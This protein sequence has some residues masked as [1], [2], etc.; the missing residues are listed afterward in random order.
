MAACNPNIIDFIDSGECLKDSFYKLNSNFN[1]LEDIVCN[2]QQRLDKKTQ[3]RTFFYYGPNADTNAQSGMD[4][5]NLSR[6]SDLTITAF[7]NSPSQLNLP[8]ISYVN[9]QVFVVYQKTGFYSTF[10]N[11]VDVNNLPQTPATTSVDINNFFYPVFIVWKLIY[12]GVAYE[13]AT[14]EGFPKFIQNQTS[15]TTDWKTPTNWTTF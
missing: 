9:D 5:G 7:V 12:N 8:S 2:L 13:I 11:N 1:I 6:P 3:I 14:N 10:G 15:S 4:S